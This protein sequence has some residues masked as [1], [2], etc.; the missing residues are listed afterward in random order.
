MIG[1]LGSSL[2]MGTVVGRSSDIVYGSNSTS[3]VPAGNTTSVVA[4]PDNTH[5]TPIDVQPLNGTLVSTSGYD[6]AIGGYSNSTGNS[7][8]STTWT[9]LQSVYYLTGVTSVQFM[10]NTPL[11]AS[12][13]VT[14]AGTNYN[15]KGILYQCADSYGHNGAT[16]P[17]ADV[18]FF[19]KYN[20][21]YY[22]FYYVPDWF[23]F[24]LQY[25]PVPQSVTHTTEGSKTG[26]WCLMQGTYVGVLTGNAFLHPFV[27]PSSVTYYEQTSGSPF[28]ISGFTWSLSTLGTVSTSLHINLSYFN[29]S[30][31]FEV[32]E[33]SEGNF[34]NENPTFDAEANV[35]AST[36]F[37]YGYTGSQLFNIGTIGDLPPLSAYGSGLTYTPGVG[38]YQFYD[39][40]GTLTGFSD[41]MSSVWYISTPHY[42][43][44][45]RT[46]LTSLNSEVEYYLTMTSGSGGRV[47][48]LSNY[49][50]ASQGV[51]ISATPNSCYH[52]TTWSGTGNGSYSQSGNPY[53]ITMNG[54]ITETAN[55]AVNV[56]TVTF[57]VS[58]TGV[59]TISP[60]VGS[61]SY[62]CGTQVPIS[63]VHIN[64]GYGFSKW[65]AT[66][67][68][69]VT[70][71]QCSQTTLTVDATGT[72]TANFVTAYYL[73]MGV[74]AGSGS[75][76]PASGY[77]NVGSQV[78][79]QAYPASGHKFCFWSGSG[80][81]SYSGLSNPATVTMNG[82]I[83]ESAYFKV[84]G[85][86]CPQAP[87]APT[88]TS[89]LGPGLPLFGALS[90][91]VTGCIS[92]GTNGRSTRRVLQVKRGSQAKPVRAVSSQ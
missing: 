10:V 4:V 76:S 82:A 35:G 1:L 69:T 19:T 37:Y 21:Y 8:E 49:Y 20:G 11:T 88:S 54:N 61:H 16:G 14:Y 59:A 84:S 92:N 28:N 23:N 31:A 55:F 64:S 34:L 86:T 81:G 83:S 75:V 53:T 2:P 67:G 39:E 44:S 45:A 71:S 90:L 60:T 80:S 66:S 24:S 57:A 77:Y 87:G 36:T 38:F 68:L 47:S 15:V 70:C 43:R 46:P 3:T 58:P 12:G 42:T 56:D 65:S 89:N 7:A 29:P 50:N 48:P 33:D 79:I 25:G 13:T 30:I 51:S 5:V 26:W 22:T 52:F 40:F 41:W 73:T 78:Q 72:V 62:D 74:T 32:D 91:R 63:I 6:W 85:G 27:S 18:L 17:I 9:N